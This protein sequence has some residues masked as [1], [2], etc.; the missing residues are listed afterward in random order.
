MTQAERV[1]QILMYGR[2]LVKRTPNVDLVDE[3]TPFVAKCVHCDNWVRYGLSRKPEVVM[4]HYCW[5]MF[6]LDWSEV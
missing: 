2:S 1:A 5:E 4:C 6:V 3:G